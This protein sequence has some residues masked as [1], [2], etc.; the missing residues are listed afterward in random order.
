MQR[1]SIAKPSEEFEVS[2]N[3]IMDSNGKTEI[4]WEFLKR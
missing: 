4:Y 1:H 3:K 2:F